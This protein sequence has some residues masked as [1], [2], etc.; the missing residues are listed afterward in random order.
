M[1]IINKEARLIELVT[2]IQDQREGW[3]GV[4]F[5]FS[6]L[7][8]HYRNSY[9]IKIAINL[10]NDLLGER[11]GA[12][13]QCEDATIYVVARDLTK[14]LIDKM[15]FQLRYLFMDD[16]LAYTRKGMSTRNLRKYTISKLSGRSSIMLPAVAGSRRCNQS[17]NA[18]YGF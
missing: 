16:P 1:K 10:M 15:V 13:F 7:L 11:D 17:T 4:C 14:P 9:Q 12:I 18:K 2:A 8:E 6:Q 3:H 5:G